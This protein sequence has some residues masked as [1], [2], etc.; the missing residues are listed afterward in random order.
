[1]DTALPWI[2]ADQLAAHISVDGAR[3]LVVAALRSGFDPA[4]DPQRGVVPAGQGH[5]LLMPATIG[6]WVGTKIASVAP[7]N[8]GKGLPRIQA[9]FLLMDAATLTPAALIE[10][11]ALTA[12]RTPA[13]SAAAADLL[14]PSEADRLV[15][16]GTGPQA[17]GHVRAMAAIRTLRAVAVS[18]RNTDRTEEFRARVSAELGVRATLAG[19]TDVAQADLVVCATTSP[20]AVFDGSLIKDGACVVAIGSHEPEFRELDADLMGRSLVVVE[21]TDTALREAGDVIRAG[22]SAEGLTPV[23]S[24]V[25]GEATRAT[26][27]PNVFKGVGMSWQDLAVAIGTRPESAS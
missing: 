11:S 12:L 27:R 25:T 2:S 24:L 4:D 17:W 19:D 1:M 14:A 3:E 21:D 23:R 26:D 6:D 16:F 8:P 10:G 5:L 22:L 9:V 18:G 7:D 20:E 15:V 13:V